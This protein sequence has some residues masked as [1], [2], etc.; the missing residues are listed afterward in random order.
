M[1]IT[2]NG[3][4]SSSTRFAKAA[5]D[6]AAAAA[7]SPVVYTA[8]VLVVASIS[9]KD[10]GLVLDGPDEHWRLPCRHNEKNN[11]Q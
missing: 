10:D 9:P 8:G 2:T 7:S 1:N 5:A 3:A 11:L 4:A 6:D